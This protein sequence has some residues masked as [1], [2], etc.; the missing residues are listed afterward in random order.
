MDEVTKYALKKKA[1]EERQRLHLSV[2]ELRSSLSDAI[3]VRKNTRTHL[4]LACGIATIVGLTMGYS[5]TGIFVR[6]PNRNM[7][8]HY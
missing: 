1:A 5:F 4:G 6:E 8:W 2:A 3:D 7:R